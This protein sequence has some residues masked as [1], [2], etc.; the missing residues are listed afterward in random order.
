MARMEWKIC[1]DA[2]ANAVNKEMY[3]I[4]YYI[5]FFFNIICI[6]FIYNWPLHKE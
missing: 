3:I 2:Y 4:I 5:V 1:M 6:L